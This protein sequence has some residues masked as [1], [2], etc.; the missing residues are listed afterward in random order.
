VSRSKINNP[1]QSIIKQAK[2]LSKMNLKFLI[3]HRILILMI[4]PKK[5]KEKLVTF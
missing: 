1:I 4:S 5:R 2:L 3:N